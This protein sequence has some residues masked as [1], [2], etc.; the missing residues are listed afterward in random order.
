MSYTYS[1]LHE[2]YLL[3]LHEL[4]LLWLGYELYLL[5]RVSLPP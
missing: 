1:T 4:Y 2:L 3:W 5:Y